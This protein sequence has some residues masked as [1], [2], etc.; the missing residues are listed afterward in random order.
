MGNKPGKGTLS[1]P[2]HRAKQVPSNRA[3]KII[4]VGKETPAQREKRIA[5]IT[6]QLFSQDDYDLTVHEHTRSDQPI[7]L[8][9][10]IALYYSGK[11][12]KGM[13]SGYHFVSNYRE[14]FEKGTLDDQASSLYYTIPSL[15]MVESRKLYYVIPSAAVKKEQHVQENTLLLS[16]AKAIKTNQCLHCHTEA[17]LQPWQSKCGHVCCVNCWSKLIEDSKDPLCPSCN[18]RIDMQQLSEV[19]LC[20][21]CNSPLRQSRWTSKCGHVAC[22]ECWKAYFSL[23][24]VFPCAVTATKEELT[25]LVPCYKPD[26]RERTSPSEIEEV[27]HA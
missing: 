3:L 24:Y 6:G 15:K 7:Y 23:A 19:T 17:M 12:G 25:Q 1:A 8:Q 16:W 20:G 10:D 26:C 21:Y 22:L 18:T 11:E 13:Q 9:D 14:S 2:G 5:Q 4:G 27:E